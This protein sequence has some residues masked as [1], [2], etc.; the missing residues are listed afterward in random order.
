MVSTPDLVRYLDGLLDASAIK[1]YCPNGLQVEGAPVV[2]R[3]VFAVTAS[4][5]AVEQAAA[6]G[7][8]A[9]IVHHGWFWRG[10]DPRVIGPRR[11][12]LARLLAAD[13]NLIGYHLPLDLHPELGNNAQLGR[14]LGWPLE[15]TGGDRNLVAFAAL[16]QPL[17]P[18]RLG[19]LLRER[20]D[21]EPLLVGDL[22]REVTRVAWCTGAAQD[23]LEAAIDMGADA[24]VSGEI[25]ERTTHL[26]REAGVIY[27]AAGHHATE[28]Y[29]IQALGQHL[30]ERFG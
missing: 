12:R 29:G 27:A 15:R 17:A 16:E 7:A 26:A 18:G 1:D 23:L 14:R 22:T 30:A 19:A 21:R 28:R 9:L 5:A 3:A 4:L 2:S 20:L 8:Q 24:F 13:L 6:A 10:E 25:S 11:R